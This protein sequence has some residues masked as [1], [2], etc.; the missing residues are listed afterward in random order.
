[1]L[2][3]R[4]LF[5]WLLLT[6]LQNVFRFSVFSFAFARGPS[7]DV[8]QGQWLKGPAAAVAIWLELWPLLFGSK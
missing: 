5:P 1:M 3:P 4:G 6:R 7:W 8:Q 2:P